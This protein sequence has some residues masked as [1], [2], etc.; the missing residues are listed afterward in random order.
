VADKNSRISGITV[1]G[2][3][4]IHTKQRIE[5][6]PLTILA[7]A[8]SAG[9]SS[10]MQPLLLL[11]QTLEA[12]GDPGALLLDGPNVRFTL[13]EQLLSRRI[14]KKEQRDDFS[15]RLDLLK[16]ESLELLFQREEGKGFEVGQMVHTDGKKKITIVPDM[17]HE[18]ILRILPDPWKS[19]YHDFR[20]K[21]K[22][23]FHWTVHRKR[24]FLSLN[25]ERQEFWPFSFS[26]SGGFVPYIQGIIHLPGLRGNPQRTYPKM[27]GGPHFQG[28]FE[29]YVASVISQWQS[30]SGKKLSDLGK[31]LQKMGL[32]WKVRAEPVD[33]TQV[34]LKVG[35]LT[36]S[37]RG[38]ARDLVSI[39]DIGFGVSQSLPVVV[40]LLAARPG[41]LVYLEQ[42]ETHLHPKAQRRLA[43]V[44]CEAAQRGVVVVVETHSPL[45]LREIQ[46]LVAS[47]KM[48][49]D[50]VKLHWLKRG[51]NGATTVKS[52][53]LDEN[54]AYG[55]WPEDFDETEL[56]AEQAYLDAVECEKDGK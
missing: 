6:K 29:L 26:P 51:A 7:G 11:K 5:I 45:L 22:K 43:D 8:N 3:K 47:N 42:P 49:K 1:R 55:D 50:M 23:T 56:E 10:F 33:D 2:F 14:T 19:L 4:S 17:T 21:E 37:K 35:R 41:Q 13:A 24:C 38:G 12:S 25:L 34:E 18:T 36:H 28:T 20:G 32:T 46:I 54:G 48:P 39:A 9:K 52:T 16:G 53:D 15:I 40:A 30:N 31:T 44:L 27:A